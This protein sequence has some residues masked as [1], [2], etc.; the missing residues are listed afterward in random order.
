MMELRVFFVED[1]STMR[2]LL[3][4]LFETVGGLRIV[5]TA[6]TEAEAM[7]WLED[8]PNGWDLAVVDLVLEQGSG[9]GVVRKAS[10]LRTPGAK[11]VVF[12]AYA[13]PA[14][15]AQCLKLG[16][17]AAFDKTQTSDFIDW[18]SRGVRA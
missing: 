1:L 9:I 13:T 6:A 15:R 11:V 3:R 12:S 10:G 17:D 14:V 16:A 5:S 8:H 2:G 4:D 18:L 7:L